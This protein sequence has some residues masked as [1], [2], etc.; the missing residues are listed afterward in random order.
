M[1]FSKIKI[2]FVLFGL[3]QL[4]GCSGGDPVV[5]ETETTETTTTTGPKS[6][7]GRNVTFLPLSILETSSDYSGLDESNIFITQVDYPFISKI[8][9][10]VYDSK[11][12]TP[13][14]GTIDDF[15]ITENDKVV[16]PLESFPILQPIGAIPT[17]LHTGIV[18]DVSG[19]VRSSIGL[20]A[21][22]AE[23]K[24]M[25][26]TMQASAD[27]VIAEQRF[28]I[29][30]FGQTVDEV[31]SGF[32]ENFD[33][34]NAALDDIKNTTVGLSSNLNQAIVEAVGIYNGP[35]GEGS[36]G[37]FTFRDTTGI[38]NDLIEEV[39]TD[40]IQLSSLI[41]ITSGT[42]SVNIFGDEQVKT[43]IESQSQILFDT[44]AS[45]ESTTVT[46]T[47]PAADPTTESATKNFGKP[48]IVVLVGND[49][50]ISPVITDNASNIIDLKGTTGALTYASEVASFQ[51]AL[52]KQRKRESD[53]NVIR[54][55]SPLRQ[56]THS[57]ILSTSAV[58]FQYSLTRQIEFE[59]VQTIG[60]PSEVYIPFSIT[61]VEIAGANNHYLQNVININDTNTF[62]PATR[63]TSMSFAASDYVWTLNGV[64]QA[65]NANT[66]SVTISPSSITGTATLG[67]TNNAIGETK[68][69]TLTADS[70]PGMLIFD[71]QNNQPLSGQSISKTTLKYVDLNAVD[72]D[73]E[74]DPTAP[75]VVPNE[76]Y[77]VIFRDYNTPLET[78]G[79]VYTLPTGWIA[80]D[81]TAPDDP[82]DFRAFG[83]GIQIQKSTI[84][85]LNNSVV[86]SVANATRG[87]SASFTI[88]P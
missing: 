8:M 66:G 49:S 51:D 45:T 16:D 15:V 58:D 11:E 81:S 24:K 38:N 60:M 9:L 84:E 1:G 31:T 72:P 62:Y 13:V 12:L 14:T 79:Y 80:F 56:G 73:A 40:R 2:I 22:I 71:Q 37:E 25:I 4:V 21:I 34:L 82:Y 17:Y 57:G 47:T 6:T 64:A 43:A 33:T 7:S 50:A 75:T 53:R 48:F 85:S 77:S 69:I 35:G 23:T 3:I 52:I 20:D 18:I 74:V 61:S 29:W 10:T 30:V 55:A 42:D 88:T 87:T 5:P 67:L 26:T 83:N 27:P 54:Y 63:W 86:I 41:L 39:S 70:S 65:S 19:S 32:T 76:V 78:Y 44:A 46:D 36:T 68:Q 28:S 59:S